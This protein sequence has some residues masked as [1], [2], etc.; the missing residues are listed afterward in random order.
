MKWSDS[1][2]FLLFRMRLRKPGERER[3][4]CV[5]VSIPLE[6][7]D[8][9]WKRFG[10]HPRFNR[11]RVLRQSRREVR[12]QM[13]CKRLSL[14]LSQV[15]RANRSNWWASLRLETNLERLMNP[16]RY[17]HLVGSPQC[18]VSYPLMCRVEGKVS[19]WPKRLPLPIS[20]WMSVRKLVWTVFFIVS[21]SSKK[22]IRSGLGVTVAV[23]AGSCS[24]VWSILAFYYK[25]R[26]K[27][28][29]CCW[30]WCATLGLFY[31][32]SW[33]I[34]VN[35]GAHCFVCV[36][37]VSI[38]NQIVK[39][40]RPKIRNNQSASVGRSGH[41]SYCCLRS[42]LIM[43]YESMNLICSNAV[44]VVWTDKL[45]CFDFVFLR[46]CICTGG[47]GIAAWEACEPWR[48][49]RGRS[50]ESG[51]RFDVKGDVFI[52]CQFGDEVCML[53]CV[54][55]LA[56][57]IPCIITTVFNTASVCTDESFRVAFQAS[58]MCELLVF[59][60]WISGTQRVTML[61]FNL[62]SVDTDDWFHVTFQVVSWMCIV[63][64][65]FHDCWI[66]TLE[67][68]LLI[69]LGWK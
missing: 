7:F 66:G 9:S 11:Q 67:M 16:E 22:I 30:Y 44:N 13:E 34:Q 52:W 69:E 49:S 63:G 47:K 32:W 46:G 18:V 65:R 19:D 12:L 42:K 31:V 5:D 10:R 28:K 37:I 58:L 45:I 8:S 50:Y 55:V 4:S 36:F 54:D 38:G 3:E 15:N 6:A 64:R 57:W 61:V 2:M 48:A 40:V 26:R 1:G 24:T 33:R 41:A 43:W 29:E 20:T 23:D 25:K 51:C 59:V 17:R 27:G 68:C 35:D 60:P 14:S 39:K 56:S 21:S 62:V 53:S